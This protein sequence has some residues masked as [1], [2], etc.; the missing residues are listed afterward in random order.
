MTR[1][2]DP[3]ETREC[4]VCG[5]AFLAPAQAKGTFRPRYC[6]QDCRIV[7]R[8][9]RRVSYHWKGKGLDDRPRF[10]VFDCGYCGRTVTT[11]VTPGHPL[12]YCS[13]T[14]KKRAEKLRTEERKQVR[15]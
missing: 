13:K 10:R 12:R 1:P 4:A 7:A 9:R 2:V 3:P 11:A 14:C 6:G 8:N 5:G 15:P